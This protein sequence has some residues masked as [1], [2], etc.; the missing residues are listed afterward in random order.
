MG[1]GGGMGILSKGVTVPILDSIQ[2]LSLGPLKKGTHSC[3]M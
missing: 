2:D 3:Q 1:W